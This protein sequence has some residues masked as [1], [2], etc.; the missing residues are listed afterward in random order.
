LRLELFSHLQRLPVA[1]FDRN[2][3]GR[4]LTRATNDIATLNEVFSAGFV[5]VISNFLQV[6][7]I[8]IWILTLNLH[9]GLIALSVFPFLVGA[10]V[11]FSSRLKIAYREARTQLSALN[12]FL[13]ENFS[14][15]KVVHLF[16]RQACHLSRFDQLNSGYAQAQMG[17]V[18][19]FA[20]FQPTITVGA[21]VSIALIIWLGGKEALG[22]GVKLGI[23][24]SYFSYILALFQPIREIAD[25]WNTF[26]SGMIAA[27]RVFSVLDWPAEVEK[28]N[29]A[30]PVVPLVGLKGH[31]VFEGVWFAYE[32]ENWA[33][34]NFSLDI[35]P[36]QTVGIVGHTGAGKSTLI[37]LLMRY[38]EPQRGRILL[39]GKDLRDYDKRSLR[40]SLGVVQQEVFLFSGT[41]EQNVTFWNPIDPEKLEFILA[42]VGLKR[43]AAEVLRE[44]GSNLSKGERQVVAFARVLLNQPK[45]WILDEATSSTDSHTEAQL[46][47]ALDLASA[48]CTRILIAHRLAT[49]QSAD[50]IVV[51]HQGTGVEYGNHESLV[52]QNGLY[53]RL[54]RYQQSQE[55]LPPPVIN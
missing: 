19:V 36:G 41:F 44:R 52:Q 25:K 9:L 38:Y 2:P 47:R 37:S 23:L 42:S 40:A 50:R 6:I 16:N 46:Q 11:Y 31:I 22:G 18:R 48:H 34:R 24:V 28:E 21:G 3:A 45:I 51:L 8:L 39:D 35:L 26:L 32:G 55:S 7:G 12:A 17:S 49:V 14:G 29:G 33:L 53:A 1:F 10:S 54:F 13:S 4:I 43:K 5:S 15:M 20:F 30:L 27:E